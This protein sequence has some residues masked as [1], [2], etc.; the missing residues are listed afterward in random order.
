MTPLEFIAAVREIYPSRYA[1]DSGGCLKFYRLLKMVFPEAR[2]Y[3]NSE[4]VI[5][6]IEG[7]FYDI[8]G[9]VENYGS[10]L[11]IDD[12]GDELINQS[13]AHVQQLDKT[14]SQ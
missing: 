12:F 3:Y 10:Y 2:G 11:P 5:T 4:H 13:F 7:D 14:L 9:I 6:E 8:D 1:A